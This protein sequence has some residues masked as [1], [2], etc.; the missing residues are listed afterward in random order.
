MGLIRP[1]QG[2]IRMLNGFLRRL[3]NQHY[4]TSASFIDSLHRDIYQ[5]EQTLSTTSYESHRLAHKSVS[6]ENITEQ[7]KFID[8]SG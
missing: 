4:S 6:V 2:F 7:Q 3:A 5:L 1:G 8:L